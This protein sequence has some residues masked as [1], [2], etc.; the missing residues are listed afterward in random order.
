MM[1]IVGEEASS[2]RIAK[3][4]LRRGPIDRS[5]GFRTRPGFMTEC[6][7]SSVIA[8]PLGPE[9]MTTDRQLFVT[10]DLPSLACRACC[11]ASDSW[12]WCSRSNSMTRRTREK[13]KG[14]ARG[15]GRVSAF[16]VS[17][18][19]YHALHKEC[20]MSSQV[21]LARMQFSIVATQST[22]LNK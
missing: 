17:L 15:R 4:L 10:A 20:T 2:R 1:Y 14:S 16:S 18:A 9:T 3:G 5:T 11:F 6:C 8:V 7:S 19:K 12:H 21:D 13:R 22:C